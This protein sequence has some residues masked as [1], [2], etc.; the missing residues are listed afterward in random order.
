[1][2]VISFVGQKGGIGKSTFAT[3][4][5]AISAAENNTLL[6]DMD[7][8]MSSVKFREIR[9]DDRAQFRAISILTST[10]HKDIDSFSNYDVIF[11]DSGG[12]E[13]KKLR[14]A[15]MASDI[16]ILPLL[17]GQFDVWSMEDTIEILEDVRTV[18]ENIKAGI[19]LNGVIQNTII[20]KDAIDVINEFSNNFNLKVFKTKIF[21]RVGYSESTQEGLSVVEMT[22]KKY[23]KAS[24]EMMKFYK[25]VEEL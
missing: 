5:A 22:G 21:Y 1:M 13:S 6:I 15:I 14:S 20:S 24:H 25:E 2:A 7:S 3:N 10:V 9:P 8:Q 12:R 19:V 11:I 16:V 23:K 4:F 18:N 17:C